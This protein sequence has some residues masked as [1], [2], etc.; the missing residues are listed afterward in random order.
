MGQGDKLIF[1]QLNS[2]QVIMAYFK[3]TKTIKTGQRGSRIE[4]YNITSVT[5]FDPKRPQFT[6]F[7]ERC[8]LFQ[9]G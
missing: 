8:I 9:K 7:K 1:R 6:L 5:V 4:L 3:V 2:C